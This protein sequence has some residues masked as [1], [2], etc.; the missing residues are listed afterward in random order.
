MFVA[1]TGL[2]LGCCLALLCC[3]LSL[4][5]ARPGLYIA[6]G[7]KSLEGMAKISIDTVDP[8]GNGSQTGYELA[9]SP[10][11][12]YF[13]ANGLALSVDAT[14]GG[15]YGDLYGGF[16]GGATEVGLGMGLSYIF[17]LRALLPY[18]SLGFGPA[19]IVPDHGDTM[20][21]LGL[22]FGAG[23]LIPL[24]YH[25]AIDVGVRPTVWFGVHNFDGVILKTPMGALGI[26]ALF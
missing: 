12:S 25:V 26:R 6:R 11:F 17:P 24:S 2:V 5:H 7:A 3:S 20:S 14:I 18:L 19:F 13:V 22:R 9:I 21:L 4:A 15:R 10:A 8:D 16:Y 1:K 23:L